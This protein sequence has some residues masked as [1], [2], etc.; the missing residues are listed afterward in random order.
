MMQNGH[1]HNLALSLPGLGHF[2][3][4][5]GGRTSALREGFLHVL[6][7]MVFSFPLLK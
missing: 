3:K 7:N 6:S 5:I 4:E 1:Y 2:L